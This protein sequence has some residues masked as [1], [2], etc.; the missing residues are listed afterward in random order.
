MADE[1][2]LIDANALIT[3]HLTYYP[4]DFAPSFWSQMEENIKNGSIVILDMVKAEITQGNDALSD[5]MDNL[6]VETLVDRRQPGIIAK[7]SEVLTFLQDDPRYQEAALHE[8]SKG[9]VADPWLIATA[10][11]KGYTIITFEKPVP[12]LSAKNPS[13]RPKIP[14]VAAGFDVQ[15][16]DLFYLMRQLKFRL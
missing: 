3:P 16:R 11:D 13:K 5:W 6:E 7:Y 8:W 2:F 9:S 14:D 15:T 10:A 4:F 12:G 1:L